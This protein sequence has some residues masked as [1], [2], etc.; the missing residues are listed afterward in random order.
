MKKFKLLYYSIL[1]YQ[2]DNYQYL[3]DNFEVIELESPSNDSNEVLQD[4]DVILAPLGYLISKE[5]I[6]KESVH[7]RQMALDIENNPRLLDIAKKELLKEG[8][9]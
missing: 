7:A 5:K 9:K 4:I 2:H 1:K 3:Q 8:N 6:D